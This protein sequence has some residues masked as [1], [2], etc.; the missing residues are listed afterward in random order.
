METAIY[1][2]VST[3]EQAQEGYS[4]RAQEQKLKDYARIKNWSVYKTYIDEGISGK[5]IKDRPAVNEL[6]E[7]MRRGNVQNVLVFKIDRLTRSTADLI[8]FVDIFNEYNCSFNS[9]MESIDTQSPSGRMFLK[10]I[11]IF[12]EF[13]REN[14]IERVK[15]GVERKVK[16]GYSLCTAFPSFGYDRPKNQKIQTINQIEAEIVKE[17][18]DL[19]VNQG[20]TLVNIARILNM[21]K[22][23]TKGNKTWS[24]TKIRRILT[25]CNY[26]GNVRH[27]MADNNQFYSI[28]GLHEPI[29]SQKLFDSATTL[30]SKN[31]KISPHK[32]PNEDKY[33]SGFL[34]CGCCGYK[35]KTYN[36]K[37]RLK[38]RTLITS[39]YVC[40]NKT[41]KTCTASSMSHKKTEKAFEDYISQIT[42]LSVSEEISITEQ[43]QIKLDNDEPMQIYTAKLRQLETKKHEVLTLYVSNEIEFN[44]YRAIKNQIE[45]DKNFINAELKRLQITK[46]DIIVNQED[47][48][49]NIN[50]NWRLLSPNERRQF[51][52]QFVEKINIVNTK[53][54][55]EFFGNAQITD[56]VFRGI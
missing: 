38:T 39:G 15:L 3:E 10:I 26:V 8:Y 54:P 5:N 37:K 35:L 56:I 32:K 45:K 11:G 1:V 41:L 44:D 21:R 33:F 51:L 27:H 47:I 22:I 28:Q 25:N 43:E 19:Y 17:I 30:L 7:D 14:I 40:P 31:Q 42:D 49:N 18:F 6:L 53:E 34:V 4:I 29:I 52:I 48:I 24:G 20:N 50:E 46:E 12:A 9:L 2:R 16:E 55:N 13:E 23:Q 36:T